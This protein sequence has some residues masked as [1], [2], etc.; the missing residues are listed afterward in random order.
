MDEFEHAVWPALTIAIVGVIGAM[1]RY[2]IA[3]LQERTARGA[4]DYV[5][6]QRSA[7]IVVSDNDAKRLMVQRIKHRMPTLIPMSDAKAEKLVEKLANG[8][9]QR[10][11][12]SVVPPSDP[13]KS[14]E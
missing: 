10:D 11:R 3:W 5:D 4:I 12:Q 6:A 13:P 1:G 7:P 9:L 14:G 2:A 8:T